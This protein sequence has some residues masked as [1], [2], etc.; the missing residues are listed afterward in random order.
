MQASTLQAMV[1][2]TFAG[3]SLALGAHW[4]YD[5]QKIVR[6]FGEIEELT[7]PLSDSQHAGKRAGDFTHYGDQTLILLRSLAASGRFDIQDFARRWRNF[8][9]D[10][11]SYV[12]QATRQTL[13]NLEQGMDPDKAG[14]QSNDLAGAARIAPLMYLCGSDLA[15]AVQAAREQTAMTHQDGIVV[16]SAEFFVRVTGSV[17]AGQKPVQAIQEATKHDF[18]SLPARKWVETGLQA[19]RQDSVS[20]IQDLGKTCHAP[21]AFSGTVQVIARHE[22]DL[23]GALTQCVMAGGDSAARG[24][25]VGTVLGAWHGIGA[26]PAQWIQALQAR[27]EI[28]GWLEELERLR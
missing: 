5:Q 23:P 17:L 27:S 11:A 25:L 20:A 19:A 28:Q 16:D 18:A 6:Q 7:A 12:D 14:S 13:A 4:M 1:W 2:A 24:M 8:W 21:H 3:D 15:A 22:D 10:S 9:I 26:L